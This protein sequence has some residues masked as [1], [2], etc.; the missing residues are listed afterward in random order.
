MGL[1][2]LKID[3]LLK[4]AVGTA[5]GG[6]PKLPGLVLPPRSEVQN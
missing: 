3:P 4:E 5:Q 6:Q 1:S 2:P